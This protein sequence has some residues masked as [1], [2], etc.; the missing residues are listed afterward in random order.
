[1]RFFDQN[2]P[3]LSEFEGRGLFFYSDSGDLPADS[4]VRY[5]LGVRA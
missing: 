4:L 3:R 1:M 2:K 5:W